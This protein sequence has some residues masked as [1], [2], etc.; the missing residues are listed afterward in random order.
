MAIYLVFF[1]HLLVVGNQENFY[2]SGKV[3][4]HVDNI[5]I[6]IHLQV[7]SNTKKIQSTKHA[8]FKTKTRMEVLPVIDFLIEFDMDIYS[9]LSIR[10]SHAATK[11]P[12]FLRH[13]RSCL[14]ESMLS[15]PCTFVY[16]HTHQCWAKKY[17]KN[18]IIF[19]S[20]NECIYNVYE[21]MVMTW[22]FICIFG[23]FRPWFHIF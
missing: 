7:L 12:N 1:R 23:M 18:N 22:Y 17:E 5:Q 6:C 21:T 9:S 3:H 2:W 11:T 4:A 13:V 10:C 15:M 16:I 8:F 20:A 14:I 19:L